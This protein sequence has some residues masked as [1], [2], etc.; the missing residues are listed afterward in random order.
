MTGD[1]DAIGAAVD[2]ALTGRAVQNKSGENEV[3]GSGNCLNCETPL[4]TSYCGTCGQTANI[5]RTFGAFWHDI[6]HGVLHFEGKFWRT[7]PLLAWHPG[8]LTR[9]YVRGERAKFISPMA[10]F[11]FSVFMLFALFAAVGDPFPSDVDGT[12]ISTAIDT[13]SKTLNANIAATEEKLTNENLTADELKRLNEQLKELKANKKT[14]NVV[15]GDKK[16]IDEIK[17]DAGISTGAPP[18][19]KWLEDI[20]VSAFERAKTNPSLLFYKLKANGYKFSWAL[21][22]ISVPFVW[23]LTLGLRG[24]HIY[25]HAVFTTYSISFMLLFFITMTLVAFTGIAG[26]PLVLLILFY[27]PFHMYR[28]LRHAYELTRFGAVIRLIFLVSFVFISMAIFIFLLLM[29][30]LLG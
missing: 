19:L 12:T 14:L 30:G 29:M 22:P 6:L 25:D 26:T 7:L 3:A 17:T 15:A 11:L 5:H 20:A 1:I 21:I 13:G 4:T 23:L 8:K 28:Q 9:R 24:Y 2:S 10:L 18:E 16:T 27:P